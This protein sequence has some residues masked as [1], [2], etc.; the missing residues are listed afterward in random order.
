MTPSKRSAMLFVVLMGVVS[1]FADMTHEG[2]RSIYGPFLALL[3]TN[4]TIVGIVTGFGELVGYALRL[5]SGYITDKTGKYW[6]IT[7]IGYLINMLAAPLLR[8]Q[9]AGKWR[10][11]S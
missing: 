4:A 9:G 2:A 8:L 5:V 1:L 3:G 10:L 7:I 6:T 11:F